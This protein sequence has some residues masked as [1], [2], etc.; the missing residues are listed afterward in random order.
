V[1]QPRI[2]PRRIR[3]GWEADRDRGR[4]FA[5]LQ[6]RGIASARS[7]SGQRMA[8]CIEGRAETQPPAKPGP[9]VVDCRP[10]HPS[11]EAAHAGRL[12]VRQDLR[13]RLHGDA[14]WQRVV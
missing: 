12:A 11:A 8:G 4:S 6:T 9:F 7:L 3:R 14:P 13:A 1:E 10:P 2:Q 5:P